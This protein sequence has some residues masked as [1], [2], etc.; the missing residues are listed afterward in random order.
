LQNQT[1]SGAS[2]DVIVNQAMREITGIRVN[3][4][5]LTA[6]AQRTLFFYRWFFKFP[7]VVVLRVPERQQGQEYADVTAAVRFLADELQLAPIIDGSPNSIPP[8]ALSTRRESIIVVEPLKQEQLNEIEDLEVFLAF[9]K[10]HRLDD[11]VW[12][13]LGGVPAHYLTMQ[14][15]LRFPVV[16]TSQG[17]PEIIGSVVKYMLSTLSDALNKQVAKGSPMTKSIVKVFREHGVSRM[18][19]MELEELKL[20]IEYPNKVFREMK[21]SIDWFV[22][23]ASN[24]VGLI[25]TENI[26]S[27]KEIEALVEKMMARHK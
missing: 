25:I 11:L 5:D 22:V 23:P 16:L 12:K 26:H 8:E 18:T 17:A 21:T 4:Y 19:V 24:A 10:E 13:V 15:H 9:L 3:M 20:E 14:R 7:P 1:Q 6:N 2:K 27:G